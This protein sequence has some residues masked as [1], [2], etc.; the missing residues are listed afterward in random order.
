MG[1]SSR[2]KR[3]WMA[4][5]KLPIVL[6]TGLILICQKVKI[7][8]YFTIRPRWMSI[9]NCPLP[10]PSFRKHYKNY[11]TRKMRRPGRKLAAL[12]RMRQWL[13][14]GRGRGSRLR[15][16]FLGVLPPPSPVRNRVAP[17]HFA[18]KRVWKFLLT[19]KGL[20]RK[21]ITFTTVGCNPPFN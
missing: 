9:K 10:T 2:T 3:S 12:A 14:Q 5:R 6:S 21:I 15:K 16:T 20:S 18:E 17:H 1:F 19:K 4:D 7:Y 11:L 13:F 8:E